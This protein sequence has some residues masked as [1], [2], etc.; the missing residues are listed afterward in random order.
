MLIHP[1]ISLTWTDLI[2]RTIREASADDAFG[3]AA[4]LAYYFLLALFPALICLLAVAS[5]LPLGDFTE[6]VTGLLAPLVPAEMLTLVRD[7]MLAISKS[8]DGGLVGLGL[9]GAIWSS[10]A[11]MV[12]IVGAM[13]RAYDIDESR[14]W[15]RVRIV[16]V[17][18]TIGL[19]VF[20]VLSALLILA[21]PEL[22]AWLAGRFGFGS[23]F[24]WAW[25]ILRWP[26]AFVLVSAGIAI[27]YYF[28]P[29]AEQEWEWVTPG[30]IVA[31]T[32]W[33]GASLAFRLYVVNFG[34]YDQSYGTIGAVI[35]LML[36][37]YLSGL[38]M[39]IGAEMNAE[40]E[41]ASPWGKQPGEKVAG[42]RRRIGR[43]AARAYGRRHPDAGIQL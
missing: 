29:D 37:F 30:S 31:T 15:W 18:L 34:H 35:V 8:D 25:A 9:L 21:G 14:P 13:N 36:W 24:V 12:A 33:L 27:V 1:S 41:H 22:A 5:F 4:Q 16:A 3:L 2:R 32:L 6:H 28:A 17:G 39:V 19:A 20:V 26:I 43:A 38:V 11:A 40:L 7:Q 23:V 10:S 42:E